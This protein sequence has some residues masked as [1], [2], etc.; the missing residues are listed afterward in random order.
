MLDATV[1]ST[2]GNEYRQLF[3][4]DKD[5]AVIVPMQSKAD[6]GNAFNRVVHE[7]RIPELGIHM[8][9]ASKESG[10]HTK[11]EKTRNI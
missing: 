3:C 10:A 6:C 7:Y 11:W 2:R 9:N 4:N 1:K 8:D 5:W